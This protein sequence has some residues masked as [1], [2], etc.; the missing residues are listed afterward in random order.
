[1]MAAPANWSFSVPWSSLLYLLGSRGMPRVV[2]QKAY[3]SLVENLCY[4]I[5]LL[6]FLPQSLHGIFTPTD[7]TNFIRSARQHGHSGRNACTTPCSYSRVL[8]FFR[9]YLK[10]EIF[11]FSLFY[12]ILFIYFLT[13][14]LEYNCFTMVC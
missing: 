11:L 7:T 14:L 13:S 2:S 5:M 8:S 1:M 9:S 3:N 4:V 12:F 6:I 10:L